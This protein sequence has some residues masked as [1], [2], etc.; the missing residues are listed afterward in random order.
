MIETDKIRACL[1]LLFA[2]DLYLSLQSEF[3]F[4]LLKLHTHLNE[5]GGLHSNVVHLLSIIVVAT[6]NSAL[7][8]RHKETFLHRLRAEM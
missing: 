3:N 1:V 2:C 7:I 4:Q 6:Y 8:H 5:Y